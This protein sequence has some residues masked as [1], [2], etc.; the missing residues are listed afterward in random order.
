[1]GRAR[2]VARRPSEA[3]HRIGVRR[4]QTLFF[5]FAALAA[6]LIGRFA[7]V[8]VRDGARLA[9][10]A[11]VQRTFEIDLAARR[12]TIYDRDLVPLAKSL[13]TQSV[14]AK[15]AEIGPP[16]AT[17]RKLAP[18]LH[19]PLPEVL[20]A[21]RGSGDYVLVAH[22][23]DADV[24]IAVTA[25]HLSG[26]SIAQ[27]DTGVRFVPSGRLA[28]TV[29]GFTGFTENGLGGIESAYDDVLRGTPG[30]MTLETDQF[31]RAIPFAQ[32][33]V[34]DP[35]RAGRSLQLTLDSYLQFGVERVLRAT[36][37]KWHAESG[38]ALVMDP[39]TGE[40]LALAN[41]PDFDVATFDRFPADARR[42]RA[43]EDAYE[44]G[45][46]FKLIT[47][48]AAL[49][50][51]E[52]TPESTFPARDSMTIGGRTIFNADDGFTGSASGVETLEAII[53]YSHNVGAAEV[54]LTI[55][56]RKMYDAI[57]RFGFGDI[58]N[59]GLPGESPGI[60]PALDEWSETSLPTIA[61]GQGIAV[62]P[63]AMARAYCAIANGGELVRPR[64]IAAEL[65]GAGHVVER[66]GKLVERRAMSPKTAAILRG[67]L[68]QVVLHG[69]GNPTA[70]VP[71]Y[72]T[73]GKT[74]TAQ[75]A[76]GG[77]YLPGA[78][79][80]SFIGMVP[81]ELPRFVVLVKIE[82]PRGQIYGSLVAAPAFAEIARLTMMH[83]GIMPSP[84]PGRIRL[85][86]EGGTSKTPL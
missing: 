56:R 66:Y 72:T 86:R 55:G 23:I 68:R 74:G 31:R 41:V 70:Q 83:A 67:Y 71:G 57:K 50:S 63:L 5:I 48:A 7:Y 18:V 73:A 61:Y 53:E 79:V 46:T 24:A 35:A 21:L 40:I 33:I 6:L 42:N 13:P 43:V 45:S 3:F 47:A 59:V 77:T 8:Q 37:A 19:R 78:Y 4:A 14:Y 28:S 64:I 1:M 15:L 62:T 75:I 34:L 81:A 9:H 26:I 54:G 17:A 49:E 80:A 84:A 52:V 25:L 27:E 29:I 39:A 69:T 12:G 51:G 82:K 16:E 22:K 38:T 20:D 60:L 11:R 32:P 36:V 2:Y 76:A 85:V 10:L 30:K 44:P 65:D 58:T